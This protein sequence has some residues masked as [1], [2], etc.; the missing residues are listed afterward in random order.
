M[1]TAVIQ[2][3]QC[4]FG[5][6]DGHRLIASSLNLGEAAATL[7][8]L[9]DLAPGTTFAQS[10]GYWTGIPLPKMKRYALM[11]TWP[12]PE[13]PRPGCVWTHVLLL[14]LSTFD[15]VDDLHQLKAGFRRPAGPPSGAEYR[16]P[17]GLELTADRPA[18][19]KP[20]ALPIAE[21]LLD[22]LYERDINVVTASPGAM[23][24]PVFAVWSQQWPRL[25]R[26]FRFQTAVSRGSLGANDF[27]FDVIFRLPESG[28]FPEETPPA[29]WKTAALADLENPESSDL[30]PFLWRY[31]SDVRKQRGS[32]RP[33]CEIDAV[34]HSAPRGVGR[35]LVQ[36][37]Q[38]SFPESDDASRL[39]QDIVDG[40]IAPT[41]QL[42]VLSILMA[43]GKG[44]QLPAPTM[45]SVEGLARFWPEHESELME[46]AEEAA[47]SDAPAGRAILETITRAIPTD[48]FWDLTASA[49]R[50]RRTMV[51]ARPELLVI[52]GVEHLE[53][54]ALLDLMRFLPPGADVGSQFADRMLSRSDAPV[55]EATVDRFPRI[56]SEKVVDF[57]SREG[58]WPNGAWFAALTARPELL[59]E[60]DAISR[61]GRASLLYD[62]AEALGWVNDRTVA[63]GVA[64]WLRALQ[65]TY[66]D[67]SDEK[68]DALFAFILVLALL[69]PG[70]DAELAIEETFSTIHGRILSSRLAWKAQ[71]ILYPHLPEIGWMKN[72]DKGLRLRIAVTYSYVTNLYDATSFGRLGLDRRVQD[73]LGDAADMFKGGKKYEKAARHR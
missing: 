20:D 48:R 64:L 37:V 1:S 44:A 55:V 71:D 53:G 28:S 41:G 15:H 46:L 5:Y 2:A 23:D 69:R 51:E 50:V 67:L 7:A 39:K 3:D 43:T 70:G 17:L 14:E 60:T 16:E 9:T 22:V 18:R 4:L 40:Q 27:K 11:Y 68:R 63:Q 54:A 24:A 19:L 47:S 35:K 45:E 38:F 31:G 32:F 12:A 73:L 56:A 25:R 10:D 49:P 65:T 30:R 26:N 58:R 8:H 66:L 34:R 13:M 72:W 59:T 62:I 21:V 57:A 42:E 52:E 36:L 29:L 33:L 6:D 61:L